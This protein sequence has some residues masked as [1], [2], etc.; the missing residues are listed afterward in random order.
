LVLS[1]EYLRKAHEQ[2]AQ[3]NELDLARKIII[4]IQPEP[5]KRE[6]ADVG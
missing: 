1:E 5:R 4:V 3:G 6:A 2:S